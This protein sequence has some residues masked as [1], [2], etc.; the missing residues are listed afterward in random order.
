MLRLF[1]KRFLVEIKAK[2]GFIGEKCRAWRQNGGRLGDVTETGRPVLGGLEIILQILRLGGHFCGDHDQNH[3]AVL[4]LSYREIFIL[5]HI[6]AKDFAGSLQK[7]DFVR[8]KFL[9]NSIIHKPFLGTYEV[10]HTIWVPSSVQPFWHLLDTNRQKSKLKWYLKF[11]N[12]TNY[13]YLKK[14]N[15]RV[16]SNFNPCITANLMIFQTFTF[17]SYTLFIV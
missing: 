12:E 16:H 10:P 13:R 5:L 3:T 17:R 2:Y 7:S 1:K 4:Q 11:T 9:K 8:G 14:R 15:W 6:T